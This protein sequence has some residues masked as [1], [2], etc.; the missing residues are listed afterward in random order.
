[1]AKHLD[2]LNSEREQSPW[3]VRGQRRAYDNPYL[4]IDDYDVLKPSGEPGFYG[5][6]RMRRVG[7]GVLPIDDEGYVHLV[8]Q[9]RF[10][11]D[12]YSWEMPEGGADQDESW[13]D[14]AR[15]ELEEEAGLKA[16]SL[17]FALRMDMS[18]SLT[19]ELCVV[20]I[21]TGLSAGSAAPDDTEVFR[22]ARVPFHTALA[23]AIDGVITDSLTVAALLR[24]HHMAVT[25]SLPVPLSEVMLRP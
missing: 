4:W 25:G 10:A 18:N 14:C 9:W 5:V 7:V 3:T 1:M 13:E 21:A 6:V 11:L 22:H 12:R 19:D 15:R 8:G 24:A 16:Q 20:F 2:A 23:A 17:Q